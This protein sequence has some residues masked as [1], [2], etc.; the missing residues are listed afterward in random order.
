MTHAAYLLSKI[1]LHNYSYIAMYNVIIITHNYTAY[2]LSKI[3][4]IVIAV[5]S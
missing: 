5:Y 3:M 2:L 4:H 1:I